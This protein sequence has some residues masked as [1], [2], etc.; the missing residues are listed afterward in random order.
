NYSA[1]L[2]KTDSVELY[3]R[4]FFIKLSEKMH[5]VK[6]PGA[7]P[8]HDKFSILRSRIYSKP[9]HDWKVETLAA[10]LTM[11]KSHFHHLYKKLFGTSVINDVITSRTEHA[12][13][14]LSTTNLPVTKV[15]EMCGYNS[16][17][18]FMKQFKA[19]INMTPSEYRSLGKK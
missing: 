19:R 14:L 9:Y 16:G 15:A 7:A 2:Y 8:Y 1:N 17:P 5:S 6:E 11:S 13:H 18:H 4:L 12:K 3:L 10:S